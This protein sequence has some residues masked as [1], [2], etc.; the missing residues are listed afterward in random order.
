MN[1]R[2]T[3][4][5]AIVIGCLC[6][7]QTQAMVQDGYLKIGD[8]VPDF[9]F[10]IKHYKTKTAKISDFKGKLIILDLWAVWCSSCIEAM[11]HM[12]ELQKKFDGKIQVIMVT[13][14]DDAKIAKLGIRSENVRNNHLP[15]VTNA[16]KL[17]GLFN[18][19][20]LPTHIWIDE[21]GKV[22]FIA[23]SIEANEKNISDYLNGKSID[24]KEKIDVKLDRDKPLI[25]SWYP[26]YKGLSIYSFLA[27]VQTAY[28]F[29][30]GLSL[31]RS[32]NGSIKDMRVDVASLSTLYKM[33]YGQGA[34]ALLYSDSRVIFNFKDSLKYKSDP[35]ADYRTG[36]N[37]FMFQLMN[38]E[39]ISD[40][41]LLRYIQQQ[42]DMVFNI[43]SSWESKP[44]ACYVIKRISGAPE[45]M[46]K[47]DTLVGT[48]NGTNYKVKH[49]E[50]DTFIN[51]LNYTT[52]TPLQ[53]LDETG[54][55]KEM[56][57]DIS[58]NADWRDLNVVNKSLQ[59]YGVKIFKEERMLD[60][61]VLSDDL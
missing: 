13:K 7:L 6:T 11:P 1:R 50:W 12:Q 3:M 35:N 29:N 48:F 38:N 40:K 55:D 24:L 25:V 51:R 52:T 59:P 23:S 58:I 42:F 39:P 34:S 16:A 33:A 15:S 28:H 19:T 45:P 31:R 2:I 26:Y 37:H 32:E 27:P 22:K 61:I 43:K 47:T 54:F 5:I 21:E 49:V 41:K 30:G 53:L 9:I 20:T 60:C 57:V 46:S 10:P 14:D 17:A 56:K 36:G 18:Y 4:L 8:Q 44:T